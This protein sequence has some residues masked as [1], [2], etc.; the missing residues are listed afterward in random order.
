VQRPQTI[1]DSGEAVERGSC[2]VCGS[3]VTMK[4]ERMPDVLGLQA[5]SL[6]D[7]SLYKPTMDVFTASAQ[8]WDHM[9]PQT[10]KLPKGL[11]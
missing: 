1:G 7:P 8:H 9:H 10:K 6:D 11:T 2:S 3:Q 4:L 5:A